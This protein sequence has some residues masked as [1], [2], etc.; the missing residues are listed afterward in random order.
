ML[1]FSKPENIH[2][3]ITRK[4]SLIWRVIYDWRETKSETYYTFWSRKLHPLE[5]QVECEELFQIKAVA[6]VYWCEHC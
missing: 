1:V 4:L 6:L 5:T 2:S 3:M